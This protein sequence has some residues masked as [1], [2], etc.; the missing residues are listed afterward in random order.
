MK[1]TDRYVYICMVKGK[2]KYDPDKTR[3]EILKA[4]YHE[5]YEYGF[6]AASLSRILRNINHTKGALYHH[7]SNKKKLGLSVIEE[8]IAEEIYQNFVHPLAHTDDPVAAL[9]AVLQRKV[10]LMTPAEMRLGC[11][12][13]NMVQEMAPIDE[14]FRTKLEAVTDNW[15]GAIK[16]ALEKGQAA[17]TVIPSINPA[18]AAL[19]IVAGVQGSLG[20]GKSLHSIESFK[21]SIK[22]LQNYVLSLKA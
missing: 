10:D 9:V 18:G 4:A 22:E 13:S 17:G 15:Q 14:L 11:P 8:M 16:K 1:H 19:F 12:L 6:Q 20:L 7:F 3:Q 5:I 2:D 21:M